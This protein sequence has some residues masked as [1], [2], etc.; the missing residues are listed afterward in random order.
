MKKQFFENIKSK[1]ETELNGDIKHIAL[2]NSQIDNEQ[3]E[4]PFRF[5]ALFLE[6]TNMDFRSETSGVQKCDLEF[7]IHCCFSQLVDDIDLLDTVQNVALALHLHSGDYFSAITRIEEQMD[8]D[9]DRV[10]D[11]QITFV[12]TLTDELTFR[13]NQLTKINTSG[14]DIGLEL[15][16]ELDI[17]NTVIRSGDGQ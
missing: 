6:F 4:K 16:R 8:S 10:I 1:L 2:W 5:P 17:D 7:V 12:C 11:W 3:T 14:T 15:T 9:H 13:E